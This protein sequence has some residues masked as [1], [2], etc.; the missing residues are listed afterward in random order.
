M[1]AAWKSAEIDPKDILYIETH[2]T[3]TRIGD[4]VEINAVSAE[5]AKSGVTRQCLLGSVKTNIGHTESAAGVAGLIKTA[6][7][8]Q[9]RMVP[10]SRNVAV[11]NPKVAWKSVPV[12][13]ATDLVDLSAEPV[14]TAWLCLSGA[15]AKRPSRTSVSAL[16][17]RRSWP[18]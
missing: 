3:G 1:R 16:T 5:L 14:R 13:I 9:H 10:P 12:R 11:L 4:R 8:V 18:I 17:T 2:G 15:T 7:T 6:L